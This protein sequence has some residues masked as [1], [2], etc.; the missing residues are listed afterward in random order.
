VS[1]TSFDLN[2]LRVL[3]A[4]LTEGS[5]ARAA[6]R[7]HVTPSA[8]SNALAR[9]RVLIG[10]RLITKKG[11][12]IVPTPRAL[13][14]APVLAKS[15][16][17]L[18]HA[19]H[20]G[21]FNPAITTRSFTIALSD[22]NQLVLLPRIASLFSTVMPRA[23]LRAISIDSIAQLGGL[24]GSEVDAVIG[25]HAGG[26]DIHAELLIDQP[27]VLVCR[28]DHPIVSEP[29]SR[30]MMATLQHVAVEM[31]PGKTLRDMTDAA[32]TA[33][34]VARHVAMTVPSFMCAAA[35]AAMTDF[36][37]TVPEPLYNAVGLTLRLRTIPPPIPPF[38]V[39]M[40]LCWHERTHT[41]LAAAG[42]RE[43]VRRAVATAPT[44]HDDARSAG[45]RVDDGPV[46]EPKVPRGRGRRTRA[47]RTPAKSSR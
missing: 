4:V 11:R 31:A 34:G 7:L 40:N 20:G 39:P 24:A 26:E 16:R 29:Q 2:L 3:D 10:D 44:R 43:L 25:P 27:T 41:D 38:S 1:I 30:D 18:Q 35:V 6:R 5:V 9:L 19:V 37:A 14:L 17:D 32:Y 8:V 45:Q 42:F 46:T 28:R 15:L 33:A 13:E 21:A 23:R 12:G 36:V 47:R 22:A